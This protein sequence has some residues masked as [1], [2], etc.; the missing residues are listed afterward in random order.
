[1]ARKATSTTAANV[2]YEAQPWQM[3][4]AL[5]NSD[6]RGELLEDDPRRAC[7]TPPAG[8]RPPHTEQRTGSPTS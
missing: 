2:G 3:A 4:D 8:R 6:W 5:R 1:M 7:G